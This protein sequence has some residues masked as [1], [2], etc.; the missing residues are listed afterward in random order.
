[1]R[2][3]RRVT[4]FAVQLLEEH[5]DGKSVEELSSE[6]GIPAERIEMRLNAAADYLR[7]GAETDRTGVRRIPERKGLRRQR[8]PTRTRFQ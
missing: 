6:T 3:T 4:P 7:R 5:R 8:S 2:G 1:M